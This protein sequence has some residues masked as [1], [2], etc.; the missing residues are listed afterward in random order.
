MAFGIEKGVS[1]KDVRRALGAHGIIFDLEEFNTQVTAQGV[2]MI[3]LLGPAGSTWRGAS[4]YLEKALAEYGYD[5]PI[6]FVTNGTREGTGGLLTRT[7]SKR[8][9]VLAIYPT[10]ISEDL[11][12]LPQITFRFPVPPVIAQMSYWETAA[13][14]FVAYL[15][16]LIC[17]GGGSGSQFVVEALSVINKRRIAFDSHRFLGRTPGSVA[18]IAYIPILNEPRPALSQRI[19]LGDI[20]GLYGTLSPEDSSMLAE[21]LHNAS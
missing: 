20:G 14:P 13:V 15:S 9:P 11:L 12:M 8:F 6:I 1:K 3:G 10:E 7:V 5:S 21:F 18:K 17:F 2:R 19:M 16:S 4:A